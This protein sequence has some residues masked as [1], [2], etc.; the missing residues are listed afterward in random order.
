MYSYEGANGNKT[1]EDTWNTQN[2]VLSKFP[3]DTESDDIL[4]KFILEKKKK[5][6]PDH[7]INQ[8]YL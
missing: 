2:N 3:E 8:E 1:D 7:G 4:S 6:Y 5:L